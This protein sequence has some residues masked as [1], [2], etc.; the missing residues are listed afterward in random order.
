MLAA[1]IAD[2][3]VAAYSVQQS[4]GKLEIIPNQ[5]EPAPYGIAT[6][7]GSSLIVALQK[8]FDALVADGTYESLLR[9]WN[10]E[11]GELP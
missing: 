9:T 5:I 7:K 6:A 10:L 11:A 4:N 8:A 2:F 3:P 1:E